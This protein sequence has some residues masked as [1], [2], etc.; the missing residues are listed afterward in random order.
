MGFCKCSAC[1][2]LTRFYLLLMSYTI[3]DI[4]NSFCDV[5]SNIIGH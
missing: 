3:T 1:L 5:G 2:D 4:L